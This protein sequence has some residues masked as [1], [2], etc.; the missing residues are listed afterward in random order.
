VSPRFG[1]VPKPKRVSAGPAAVRAQE[2]FQCGLALHQEGQLARAAECYEQAVA[3]QPT[4]V[5][6]LHMRG[7]IAAQGQDPAL[8]IAWIDRAIAVNGRIPAAFINRGLAQ[9]AVGQQDAALASFERAVRLAPDFAEAHYNRGNAQLL[10]GRADDARDS[11]FR[12]VTLRP[13]YAEAWY[14]HGT[15]LLA[16]RQPRAA[17]ESFDRAITHRPGYAEAY[18]NRANAF[19]ELGELRSALESVERATALKPDYAEA[20][21]NQAIFLLLFGQFERGWTLYERR[22]QVEQRSCG[23]QF[24]QPLWLGDLPPA[25]KTI[26]LHNEQGFGD[27]LQFCR[28]A[29]LVHD[30]GAR[31]VLR[32]QPALKTVL[33]RLEGVE[34]VATEGDTMPAF[35]LHCPLLSLP[36]AFG[37]NA[38]TIPAPLRYVAS[39][40]DKVAAWKARLGGRVLPRVGL[41]WSSGT[42][43]QT[44]QKRNIPLSELVRHLPA[45]IQYVSLQKDVRAT[46]AGTLASLKDMPHFGDELV[47][48]SD[49]AALCHLM[50]LVVTVD[51]SVAH[52]AGAMGKPVWILLHKVPDWRWLLDRTDSPWYPSATLFRQAAVGDWTTMLAQLRGALLRWS[53]SA[54]PVA[55]A[56]G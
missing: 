25:G 51:T 53:V 11:F 54:A 22:W 40:P 2:M 30:L 50:D 55:D 3:L 45:G 7:V 56:P 32:V 16:L 36:L 35:D 18:N 49:T 43:K 8:A 41:C 1:K 13:D 20:Q 5:D 12:A 44:L 4:H 9:Q 34:Q 42:S 27:T 26:L 46:D 6:A 10:L 33:A 47:D 52:L 29:K 14:N 24:V 21:W 19:E 17:I 39:D 38:D 37:T 15:A 48:F 31:V 23:A 28:Y